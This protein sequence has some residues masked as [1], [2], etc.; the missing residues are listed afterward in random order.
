MLSRKRGNPSLVSMLTRPRGAE[1]A[2]AE[3]GG[4]D[5]GRWVCVLLFTLLLFGG[6]EGVLFG[7][8][9]GSVGGGHA[10]VLLVERP[11]GGLPLLGTSITGASYGG[12]VLRYLHRRRLF[13]YNL[14]H[15]KG[16]R[17]FFF[18]WEYCINIFFL[19]LDIEI[20]FLS[21]R[22]NVTRFLTAKKPLLVL[23]LY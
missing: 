5:G 7:E 11:D 15:G 10:A 19:K 12:V 16:L 17:N 2:E 21:K 9:D 20:T 14:T 22:N 8:V 3:G 23:Y 18:T 4:G 6:A 1:G 13:T